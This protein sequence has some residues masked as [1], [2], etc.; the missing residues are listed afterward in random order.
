MKLLVFMDYF[1]ACCDFFLPRVRRT[2]SQAT[3]RAGVDLV[4]IILLL[5]CFSYILEGVWGMQVTLGKA[6]FGARENSLFHLKS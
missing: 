1:F 4:S 6:G 3:C 5:F 2:R